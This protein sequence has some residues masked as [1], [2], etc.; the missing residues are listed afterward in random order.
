LNPT[1]ASLLGLLSHRSPRTGWELSRAF[2]ESI[3]QFWSITRSQVYRE[4]RTLAERGM[5]EMGA[6]GVRDRRE[7]TITPLGRAAFKEW[8][9]RTPAQEQIRFPL[10]LMTFFGDAV[11]PERLREACTTQRRVHAERLA[12]YEGL[13]PHVQAEAYPALAL[14]FGIRFERTV[15]GWID[16]LPWMHDVQKVELE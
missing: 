5:I 14:D 2:E 7:C 8:I 11:P 15:L 6:S 12:A 3:G 10:L 4:L 9:A 1:A 16:D 13:L